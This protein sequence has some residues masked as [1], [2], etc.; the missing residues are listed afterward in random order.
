MDRWV[1]VVQHSEYDTKRIGET[2]INL[3][4]VDYICV[5][6]NMIYFCGGDFIKVNDESM[7]YL[8]ELLATE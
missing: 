7:I 4:N 3:G 1:G 6:T 5:A 8:L 2:I